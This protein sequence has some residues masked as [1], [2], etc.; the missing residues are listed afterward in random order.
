MWAVSGES[1]FKEI[2]QPEAEQWGV[3]RVAFPNAMTSREN[4]RK[5]PES[6]LPEPIKR[7]EE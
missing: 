2:A 3:W 6:I 5:N 7:E 1:Y 4:V